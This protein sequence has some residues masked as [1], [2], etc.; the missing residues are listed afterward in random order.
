LRL[1]LGADFTSA[2]AAVLRRA[3]GGLWVPVLVETPR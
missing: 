3:I 2:E 1:I